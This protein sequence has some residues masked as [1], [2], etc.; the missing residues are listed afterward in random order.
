MDTQL[1]RHQFRRKAKLKRRQQE[2]V[3]AAQERAEEEP[4]PTP[5]EHAQ[6]LQQQRQWEEREKRETMIQLARLKAKTVEEKAR[7]IA[8]KTWREA[9]LRMPML[10][11]T[12]ELSPAKKERCHMPLF[13]S[14]K[15][16]LPKRRRYKERHLEQKQAQLPMETA[17]TAN[18]VDRTEAPTMKDGVY[19]HTTHATHTTH[20]THTTENS[21]ELL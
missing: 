16:P 7:A 11:P 19:R 9:L 5:E 15:D 13:V 3:R 4:Q 10:P 17:E 8:E 1:P 2:R 20:T 18:G 21:S 6:Y 12:F 14:S